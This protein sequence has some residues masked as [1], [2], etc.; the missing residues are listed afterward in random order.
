MN[1]FDGMVNSDGRLQAHLFLSDRI[2][3]L[4]CVK[5]AAGPVPA[6]LCFSFLGAFAK[7]GK[8]TVSFVMSVRPS[9]RVAQLGS[10]WTDFH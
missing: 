8:A 10:H 4:L 5:M 9:V 6:T 1:C 7:S 3:V 2:S